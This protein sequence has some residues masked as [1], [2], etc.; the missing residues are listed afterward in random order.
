MTCTITF[1]DN[2]VFSVNPFPI[3]IPFPE[4][5]GYCSSFISYHIDSI[6]YVWRHFQWWGQLLILVLTYETF[7]QS[8]RETLAKI[9]IDIDIVHEHLLFY[10]TISCRHGQHLRCVWWSTI[11]ATRTY[12]SLSLLQLSRK[13]MLYKD[14]VTAMPISLQVSLWSLDLK[15]CDFKSFFVL[16]LACLLFRI[17]FYLAGSSFVDVPWS[18]PITI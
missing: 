12:K 6:S 1:N 18:F 8:N 4:L 15:T 9:D 11:K 14:F 17:P 10:L 5:K 13:Y 2:P 16:G 7:V 3:L